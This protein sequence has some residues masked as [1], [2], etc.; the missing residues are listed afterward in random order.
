M[1]ASADD[2]SRTRSKN[3]SQHPGAVQIAAKRKRRTKEQMEEDN[4]AQEARKREKGLKAR[5]QIKNI[6]NLEDDMAKKD[7]DTDCAHPRSR[8]GNVF[9]LVTC[10]DVMIKTD[11]PMLESDNDTLDIQPKPIH[12]RPIAKNFQRQAKVPNAAVQRDRKTEKGSNYIRK[13]LFFFRLRLYM[14]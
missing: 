2:T 7:A 13:F 4:A 10:T 5:K 9:I 8:N 3:K 11:V 12:P 14:T 1:E 6:A